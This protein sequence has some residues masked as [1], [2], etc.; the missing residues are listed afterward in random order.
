MTLIEHQNGNVYDFDKDEI[1][2]LSFDIESP[3]FIHSFSEVENKRGVIDNGSYLKTR[4]ISVSFFAES[5]N[6]QTFSLLRD[7][8]F[9]MVRS[10][11]PFYIT[12]QRSTNKRWLVKVDSSYNIPQVFKHGKFEIPFIALEGVAESRKTTLDLEREGIVND[13]T[14]SYG[15]GLETV[16]DTE[17][18]YV[19]TGKTF[20]I[21]NAG[22][23]EVHPFES[24]LNIEIKNV[25]GSSSNFEL[26][27][28]TNNS[29]F[30]INKPVASSEVWKINGPVIK[31]NSLMATR[32][33]TKTFISL[34]PG[35][36]TFEILGASSATVSFDFKYLYL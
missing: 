17:L 23:V 36:N 19:H 13:N 16:D 8:I 30:K 32:D 24:D 10:E 27:N 12:E 22:N 1:R 33:T 14:W 4:K 29:R 6:V 3:N 18:I 26:I 28:R 34:E 31:R 20:K 9:E 15:M 7:E 5:S 2:T 25:Q 35:W 21:F 11:K